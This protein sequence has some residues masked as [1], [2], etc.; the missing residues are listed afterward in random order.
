VC[1]RQY[2]I[3]DLSRPWYPLLFCLSALGVAEVKI[4]CSHLLILREVP[5]PHQHWQVD[6]VPGER[7]ESTQA[8]PPR[9]LGDDDNSH[10]ADGTIAALG[11]KD[12]LLEVMSIVNGQVGSLCG[13]VGGSFLYM[14]LQ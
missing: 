7:D 5:R 14:P 11:S 3:Y 13:S 9:P 4:S 2:K 1:F 6:A 8:V 12:M 10:G